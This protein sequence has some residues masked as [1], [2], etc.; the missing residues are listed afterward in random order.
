MLQVE[1]GNNGIGIWKVECAVAPLISNVLAIPEY[2]A[3]LTFIPKGGFTRSF[4]FK[5]FSI[6]DRDE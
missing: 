4:F 2:A 6:L 3:H 1:S 5:F